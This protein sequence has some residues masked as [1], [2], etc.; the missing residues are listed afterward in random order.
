MNPTDRQLVASLSAERDLLEV[1]SGERLAEL[2]KTCKA[3][4]SII[5]PLAAMTRA[6]REIY[7]DAQLAVIRA[8][9]YVGVEWPAKAE[10]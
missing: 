10:A 1:I 8:E 2:L 6:D 9:N 3:L 7:R 5:S 4:L